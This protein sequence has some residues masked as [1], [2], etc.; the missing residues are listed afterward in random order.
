MMAAI[1]GLAAQNF[2]LMHAASL[3]GGGFP[4]LYDSGIVYRREPPGQEDWQNA[5]DLLRTQEGD[6]EDL[7]AYRVGELRNE[8]EPATVEIVRNPSGSY[9][10]I[11]RRADGTHEDPSRI[12]IAQEAQRKE[13]TDMANARIRHRRTSRGHLG[14]IEMPLDDGR[15]VTVSGLG[16]SP[17]DA[18]KKV[19]TTAASVATN[20]A[21]A[22]YLPPGVATA[23]NTATKLTQLA[24]QNPQ[25]LKAITHQLTPQARKLARLMTRHRGKRP[26]YAA[27]SVTVSPPP[28]AAPQVAPQPPYTPW[29]AM[30][31]QFQASMAPEYDP[32]DPSGQQAFEDAFI[33]DQYEMVDENAE[34]PFAEYGEGG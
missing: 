5:I 29:Q 7:S 8:G 24:T 11:V 17:L 13:D 15:R 33:N 20:P 22:P 32:Q 34:L 31:D 1:E 23:V 19:V 2:Q 18:L 21:I 4:R 9:H 28:Q 26:A 25:A 12:L 27:P 30:Y 3:G 10:A 14:E 16:W 6:C